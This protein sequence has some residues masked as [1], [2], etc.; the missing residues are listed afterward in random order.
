MCVCV[1]VCVCVCAETV[2][3]CCTKCIIIIKNL[4]NEQRLIIVV[5]LPGLEYRRERGEMIETFKIVHGFYVP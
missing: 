3:R 2:Q 4:E 5:K 1:C